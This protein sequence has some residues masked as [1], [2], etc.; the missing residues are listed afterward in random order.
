ME[1][2][3][4][5]NPG[6]ENPF[7]LACNNMFKDFENIIKEEKEPAATT[8]GSKTQTDAGTGEGDDEGF[9]KLLG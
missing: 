3:T 1:N 9:N 5:D 7:L 2:L 4:K 8:N 6:M